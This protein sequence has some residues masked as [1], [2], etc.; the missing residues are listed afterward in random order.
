[1]V[2]SFVQPPASPFFRPDPHAVEVAPSRDLPSLARF[3]GRL[4][5]KEQR[6]VE[7]VS[8]SS[9]DGSRAT[10]VGGSLRYRDRS[11]V[12]RWYDNPNGNRHIDDV[13]MMSER[14]NAI[15]VDNL[16]IKRSGRNRVRR[17]GHRNVSIVLVT[18]VDGSTRVRLQRHLA[19]RAAVGGGASQK[20]LAA[21]A[22]PTAT[23]QTAARSSPA[24]CR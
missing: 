24:R 9:S 8:E 20:A 5:S 12:L 6:F 3:A 1:L 17:S 21:R 22:E 14:L 7:G 4:C 10:Q 19:G 2:H 23:A 11:S 16:C 18:P 15:E 13:A